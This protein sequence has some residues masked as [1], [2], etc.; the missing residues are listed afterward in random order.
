MNDFLKEIYAIQNRRI[1]SAKIDISEPEMVRK[2]WAVKDYSVRDSH[3]FEDAILKAKKTRGFGLIAEV[4]FSSPGSGKIRDAIGW[5]D[6][7][8]AY[9]GAGADCISVVTEEHYFGGSNNFLSD[10]RAVTRKPLLRKDFIISR[11]QIVE[12]KVLGADC[13]LLIVALLSD[14]MMAEYLAVANGFGM[15]VIVEV[16]DDEELRRALC[17]RGRYIIGVNNRNL[18]DLSVSLDVTERLMVDIPL[19]IATVCESG[20]MSAKDARRMLDY[21]SDSFLI[22]EYFMRQAV[23]GKA[24]SDF[25][26]NVAVSG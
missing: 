18:K 23:I 6:I 1:K 21:Y 4:K 3:L 10:I 2:A 8:I 11:Y 5:T 14:E 22:G 9:D 19:H 7:A 16:H 25:I 26:K 13:I 15:D 20:I 12:S 17:L 24:V